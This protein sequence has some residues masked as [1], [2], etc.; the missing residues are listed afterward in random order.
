MVLKG[1]VQGSLEAITAA[2]E[3]LGNDEVMARV[4]HGG[5]GGMTESD[6]TLATA[7]KAVILGFNVRAIRRRAILPSRTASRSATT[8]SSTISSTT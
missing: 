5:V 4:I 6:V 8:T 3:K 1:D 2:L 7:S